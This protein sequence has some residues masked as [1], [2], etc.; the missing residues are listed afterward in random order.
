MNPASVLA[1]KVGKRQSHVIRTQEQIL[2]Q[3]FSTQHALILFTAKTTAAP[4]VLSQLCC[5]SGL[6]L[7]MAKGNTLLVLSCAGSLPSILMENKLLQ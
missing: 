7:L 4:D 1:T 3:D 5:S 6:S 2:K